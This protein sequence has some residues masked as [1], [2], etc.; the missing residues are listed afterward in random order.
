[1]LLNVGVALLV[2]T[3]KLVGL[4]VTLGKSKEISLLVSTAS[5]IFSCTSLSGIVSDVSACLKPD[6]IAWLIPFW[7]AVANAVL[8]DSLSKAV[9]IPEAILVAKSTPSR[10]EVISPFIL[11][12]SSSSEFAATCAFKLP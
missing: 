1:M 2:S 6:D 3:A 11:P 10:E 8:T 12:C 9:V 7:I 4:R 5:P